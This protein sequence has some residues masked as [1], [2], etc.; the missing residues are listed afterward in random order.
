MKYKYDIV[1]GKYFSILYFS[2]GIMIKRIIITYIYLYNKILKCAYKIFLNF[3]RKI[4][5]S[6]HFYYFNKAKRYICII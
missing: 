2:I 1:G 4:Q 6:E 5:R 3:I